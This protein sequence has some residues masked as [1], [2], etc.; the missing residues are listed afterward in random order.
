[1]KLGLKLTEAQALRLNENVNFFEII[2]P[3]HI[4]STSINLSPVPTRSPSEMTT[5][6]Y[7]FIISWLKTTALDERTWRLGQLRPRSVISRTRRKIMLLV[8]F[9]SIMNLT[10]RNYITLKSCL[11]AV[12][13]DGHLRLCRYLNVMAVNWSSNGCGRAWLQ[14]VIIMQQD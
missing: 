11:Q 2:N 10:L 7:S 3:A 5:F 9:F 6:T 1:M 4:S 13:P 14:A 12:K 8:Y